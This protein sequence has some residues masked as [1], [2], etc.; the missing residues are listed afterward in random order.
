MPQTFQMLGF[1]VM[2]DDNLRAWLIEVNRRPSLAIT[3]D[4]DL[5]LK[6]TMVS[7]IAELVAPV[8]FDRFALAQV[9]ERRLQEVGQSVDPGHE[10]HQVNKDLYAILGGRLPRQY[11]DP[12]PN[13][14]KFHRLA[15]SEDYTRLQIMRQTCPRSQS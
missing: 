15:P 14:D 7:N 5:Y 11:G 8:A 9:V 13:S 4:L 12:Q 3:N 10:Q 2:F 6:P 1:D